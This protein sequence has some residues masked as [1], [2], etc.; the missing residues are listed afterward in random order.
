[1]RRT[2]MCESSHQRINA[3]NIILVSPH[4]ISSMEK[5]V[6]GAWKKVF[7]VRQVCETDVANGKVDFDFYGFEKGL[8]NH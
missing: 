6:D 1:M 4:K 7:S 8:R 2:K 5:Q 3:T